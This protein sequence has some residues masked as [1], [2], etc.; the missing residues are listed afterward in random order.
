MK[1]NNVFD[2]ANWFL[3]NNLDTPRN[4]FKGNMKLQKLLFFAQLI[5]LAKNNKL[6]FNEEFCAFENSMVMESVR[7]EYKNN[8]ANLLKYKR[9]KINEE[10]LE[11]LELTK[12]IYG[13]ESADTL[14]NMSHQFEYWK[15]YLSLSNEENDY[16]N[17][18]KS[19]VPNE[20]LKLE[21]DNIRDVLDAY[22]MMNSKEY[23]EMEDLDY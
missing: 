13:G 1:K 18:K 10:D 22:K 19:V 16:K 15:K 14:S 5:S 20:E 12:D 21:L 3:E 6:L 17:K 8:L 7:L 23:K 2:Y 4:T 11:V 9:K